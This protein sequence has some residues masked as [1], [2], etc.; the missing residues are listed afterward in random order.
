MGVKKYVATADNTITN[1]FKFN[2]TTRGTGSNMGAADILEVFHIYAQANSSSSENERVII[3]FPISDITTNR[4]DG[5]IPASGSVD[6]YL[7]LYNAKHS[8]TVP[9]DF[10]LTI[11]AI[12]GSQDGSPAAAAWEE[13]TGLDM[14]GYTDL[15]Y[16]EK[17][18]DWIMRHGSTPWLVAGGDYYTD[19]SSS[20]TASF[21]SGIEDLEVNI[22]PLV[23]QW[24]NSAGNVLGSKDNNG[25][26]IKLRN[27]DEDAVTSYYTK[28][29]FS[30]T[31]EFF[32]KRP[33]IEARWDSTKRDDRGNLHFSSS[34]APA[35]DNLNTLYLYNVINGQLRN[36][37]AVG[38][39]GVWV[40]LYSGSS[41]NSAPSSSALVLPVGGGVVT[42]LDTNITGGYVST[43]IYSASFAVTGTSALTRVF[44]VWHLS[45]TQFF[46][47]SSIPKV[48][49]TS[50]YN[51]NP[52]FVTSITNLK[53]VYSTR[54]RDA[55]IRLFT[56]K[57]DWSPTI[58]TV[59]SKAANGEIINDVYYKLFRVTDGLEIIP[60]ATGSSTPQA[61]G[62]TQSY[63]RLSY[64]ASGSY[65][66]VDMNIL[67]PGYAYALQFMHFYNNGYREQPTIFK[68]RVE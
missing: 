7:R 19:A 12:S 57:E 42:A 53:D 17:G 4:T 50:E 54:E 67:E 25:V 52:T 40:S 39:G 51:P 3:Q 55:R 22:T 28:K 35:A 21:V 11:S 6:F 26:L 2:L 27:S 36:I 48:F 68:F 8:Q 9:R 33:V 10:D 66:D 62:N 61:V 29:F 45:G 30:R 37:P 47:G 59:A 18:S 1:A 34:V 63:T 14:E 56:R 5:T 58:Y 38:T 65:I 23:E 43:G 13:G 49:A 20:F 16:D 44:D 41:D 64:D 24:I 46:T 15:T 31:S 32:L 60:F